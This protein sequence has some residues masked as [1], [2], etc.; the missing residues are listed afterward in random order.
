MGVQTIHN[1]TLNKI[2]RGHGISDIVRAINLIKRKNI[3]L[4]AHIILGLPGETYKDMIETAKVIS[5]LGIDAVKL[6]MLHVVK[7]STLEKDYRKDNILL[8]SFEEYVSTVVKFIENLSPNI[9]IQ[10]LVSEADSDI[11]IAP[12]WLANKFRIIDAID[13]EIENQDTLQ[14]KFFNC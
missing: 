8:M 5:Y 6:H 7:G 11:L 13:K 14:G 4:C 9:L 2:H 12:D 10:R 1:K 3:N